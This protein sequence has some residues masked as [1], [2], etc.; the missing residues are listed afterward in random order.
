MTGSA[1]PQAE[2]SQAKNAIPA[3]A[4]MIGL[5]IDRGFSTAR[6]ISLAKFGSKLEHGVDE[7]RGG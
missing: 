2:S 4:A 1:L 3:P 7:R 6:P 5:F